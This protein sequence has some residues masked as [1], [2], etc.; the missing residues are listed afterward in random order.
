[1]LKLCPTILLIALLTLITAIPS[2]SDA[3]NS[4]P[5]KAATVKHRLQELFGLCRSDSISLA[6]GYCVYRGPDKPRRWRDV[7]R[8]DVPEE[9]K[10]VRD[11]CAEI[12]ARLEQSDRYEFENFATKRESEGIWY[13]WQLK[14][15]RG[16]ASEA[17]SFAFLKVKGHYL[18][19]DIDVNH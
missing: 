19:G 5:A 8:P 9:R 3:S 15:S 18:L 1:M 14:F 17:V 10:E 2:S 4:Q 16:S 6:A 7:Y 12:K 13:V 11:I